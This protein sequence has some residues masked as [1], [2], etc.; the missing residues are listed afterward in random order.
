M[1]TI[2]DIYELSPMQQGMLFHSLYNP[3]S[4]MYCEQRSC[5]LS[6]N[7]S[8]SAFKRAWQQVID[9]HTILRTAFHWEELEK[10][11]QVVYQTVELPWVEYDWRELTA[12]EQQEKLAAFLAAEQQQG[13]DLNNA[14]L[15]R[16]ALMQVR[17]DAYY[18]VWNYH[19]LLLD[20]WCNG[21]LLKEVFAF[22]EAFHQGQSL[23]LKPSRPYRDYIAW[24]Q[25]QDREQAEVFWRKTLKGLSTPTHLGI[26]NNSS[27]EN[28]N[29]QYY[30]FS[31]ALTE[32][33]QT[34]IQQHRLTLNTLFQGA[35]ALL[36]SRYSGETDIIF[37]AT[38]S[39]RPPSLTDVESMVG[40]FINTLP[41][42]VQVKAEAS[43]LPWLQTLQI[44]NIEKEQY[45]YSSLIE[46]QKWSEIPRGTP[47]FE[48]L[49]IFENYP[50]SLDKALQGWS[51]HL[52]I[53]EGQGVEKT[54]YPL[55][56]SVLPG[57]PLALRISYDSDRFSSES[58]TRLLGHLEILLT[59]IVQNPEQQLWQL[60]LLTPF[61]QE[62][63]T[64]QGNE[65]Q[66]AGRR[67]DWKIPIHQ[68]F[69]R[70]VKKTPEAIALTFENQSLT[71]Q[72]LNHKANQLAHYL[73][74]LGIKPETLVGIGLDPSI[75]MVVSLLAILKAGG[76]YLPLDPNYPAQRLT[77][78]VEDS[79][80]AYLVT[81][82]LRSPL[83]PLLRG[84][85]I[86]SNQDLQWI[87]DLDQIQTQI[88]QQP[89]TNLET[90][91]NPQ[92]LA[93]IIYTSGSTGVPKGVQIPHH[94][95]SNFL[96]SMSQK[97][98]LT[99]E[100]TLLSVTT[101]SFDIAALELY[102]PLIVG[103]KLVLVSRTL[104]QDGMELAQQLENHQVTFM[105][106][107]PAT[108]KLLLASGWQGKQD[109][110]ILSGG[111]ALELRLAQQLQQKSKAVWN[112]YGPTETTIWS[113]VYQVT[114]DKVRLG[115]P[116]DNTQF[117]VLDRDYNPVPIGVPGEL[118][119]GGMGVA[120][121]YLNRPELTAK[122][123]IPSPFDAPPDPPPP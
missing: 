101:L 17:E 71:Y 72:Q 33:L 52:T 100:D 47:L 74:Q 93:Y 73:Q 115:K 59:G 114:S 4:G 98:G 110:T 75:E 60:S 99:P 25:Q 55:T 105:Q 43:L 8:V 90:K 94:A 111:E 91:I 92:N 102:L 89:T 38:V 81:R 53:S 121:G 15:M 45:S 106:G 88:N 28:R 30:Q 26:G 84:D 54:N 122:R 49:V 24:L 77:F 13:F 35:W 123:F 63:L 46:I 112:L 7:L 22:Y 32:A 44:Q 9:R 12:S 62:Q 104:A 82:S 48:S 113:S 42:R 95:L 87:I 96:L 39:G 18:F 70:Q 5:L 2:A 40:L 19:H 6:G 80:I 23:L 57:S 119:I 1:E 58:M 118:Y 56:L 34:L 51:D 109:L 108:W 78:M 20:G 65:E 29:E 3:L 64:I 67:E 66:G 97:P 21:I 14:P 117:Y 36:L 41:V 103:A 120:R 76:T 31:N 69:E 50:I 37:G 61:E 79:K 27:S 11:L 116:I 85:Q 68:L 16:C 86:E 10:P 83:P 107:T